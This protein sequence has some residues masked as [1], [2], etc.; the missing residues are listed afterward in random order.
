MKRARK[1]GR[2]REEAVTGKATELD[3]G[4]GRRKKGEGGG[5]RKIYLYNADFDRRE[6]VRGRARV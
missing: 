3:E 2:E 6:A 4:Q 5:V 1:D